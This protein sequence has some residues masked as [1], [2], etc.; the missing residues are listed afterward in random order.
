MKILIAV[1]SYD[2][3]P[4]SN[5]MISQKNSWDSIGVENVHTLYYYGWD[6]NYNKHEL[7]RQHHKSASHDLK[8]AFTDNYYLMAGKLKFALR[9]ALTQEWDIMFRTN[10]S[11]YVNKKNLLKFAA[12]LPKEKLYAGW[13]MQ[14]TNHDGGDCVSGA[15]IFLSRDCCEILLKEIDSDYEIEEDVYIG[16]LLRPH[17]IKAID[18]R[19]RIEF[20]Q[21]L[22]NIDMLKQA[23][24]IR[25]KTGD[26]FRDAANMIVA[27]QKIIQ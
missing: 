2:N 9:W 11:S 13:T 3:P 25:F 23:Y 8:L 12:D 19:S 16:R 14:D 1:L 6:K 20:H 7:V 21:W 24:H 4:F 5:L 27:H 18:D 22:T 17:G 10:S 26:R 15:G